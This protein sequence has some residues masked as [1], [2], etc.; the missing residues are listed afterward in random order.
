MKNSHPIPSPYAERIQRARAELDRRHLD[1]Y[2]ILNRMDQIWLTG[3]TGEDGGLLLSEDQIVLLTDGRFT[4]S[5]GIEAPFGRRVIRKDRGPK[6][7][8]KEVK[9]LKA[10]KL[11]FEPGDMTVR[12][13]VELKKLISPARLV[14]AGGLFSS[15]REIKDAAEIALLRRAIDVAQ[16][17]FRQLQG[18]LRPGMT[19]REVAARLVFEMQTLGAQEASFNPI[20][21]VGPSGSL[22]HY[23]PSDN[24]VS[25]ESGVLIDW[26]ARCDWYISDLTRVVWPGKVPT[27]LAK[28]Y[29]VVRDAQLKAIAAIKPGV[30]VSKIDAVARSHIDKAGFG[31]QFNHSLGH[32]IGLNVHEAPGMRKLSKEVLKPGMVVT[33]EPGVYLPGVGGIRIEDDVLVTERG[34]EVLSSLPTE[35]NAMKL[36]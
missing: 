15:L 21:A 10:R 3:F 16:K 26:G 22:P 8:A 29:D 34:N 28:V 2:L 11:G 31:K 1:A 33:V 18:W 5:A 4:E 36:A 35:L 19:E 6:S 30:K 23:E 9:R 25:A 7:T 20:V 27:V 17:A 24:V 12:T 32:G 13:Y 14:S